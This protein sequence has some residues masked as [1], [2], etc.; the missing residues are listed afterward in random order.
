MISSFP[1][2]F[3]TEQTAAPPEKRGAAFWIAGLVEMLLVATIPKSQRGRSATLVDAFKGTVNSAAPEIRRPLRWT[4]SICSCAISSA[5]TSAS[6]ALARGAAHMLPTAPQP[7]TQIFMAFP[8]SASRFRYRTSTA[9]LSDSRLRS[10]RRGT[11]LACTGKLHHS[12][13]RPEDES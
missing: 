2:P 11:C 1:T 8:A 5:Y 10:F 6:P 12:D 13:P 7:T 9:A 3:C 4:A